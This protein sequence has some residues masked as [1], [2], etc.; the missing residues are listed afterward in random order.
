MEIYNEKWKNKPQPG[1]TFIYRYY[2]CN[3]K[4][5]IGQTRKSLYSRAGGYSGKSYIQYSS[6]F[7]KAILENGFDSFEWEILEEVPYNLS[8]EKEKYYVKKYNSY[9]EGYNS[10]RGGNIYYSNIKKI[11]YIV[12]L[13]EYTEKQIAILLHNLKVFLNKEDSNINNVDAFIKHYSEQFMS[14][15]YSYYAFNDEYFT[16]TC[17][18]IVLIFNWIDLI[19]KKTYISQNE[20]NE[21]MYTN[22][23]LGGD[24]ITSDPDHELNII[25]QTN[26]VVKIPI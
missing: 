8:N 9:K 6:P 23:I 25:L 7:Q 1:H 20:I 16:V 22:E 14:T 4:S 12:D 17:H 26:E 15:T 18:P 13:R 10:T 19:I 11:P 3:G 2:D 5:Y 21:L 24:M